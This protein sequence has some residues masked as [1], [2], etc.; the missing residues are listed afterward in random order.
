MEELSR[1]KIDT[2]LDNLIANQRAVD[3]Q[4]L[5]MQLARQKWPDII[6]SELSHDGGEDGFTIL[7][8]SQSD[9]GI[10]VACSLTATKAKILLD[11]RRIKERKIQVDLLVF[12]TPRILRRLT[13]EPWQKEVNEDFHHDLQVISREDIAEM[14]LQPHNAWMC[15]RYLKLQISEQDGIDALKNRAKD[16]TKRIL[17]GWKRE[18]GFDIARS[19]GLDIQLS[20]PERG[21]KRKIIR[22]ED[23]SSLLK[24]C[25]QIHLRGVPGAGKS[26]TLIQLAES[27]LCEKGD[28]LP[29][30]ISLPEWSSHGEDLISFIAGSPAI[31]SQRLSKMDLARLAD[32]SH[33]IFLMNGWN[34]VPEN[35]ISDM[36]LRLGKMLRE[37]PACSF[38]ISTRERSIA[39]PR[40]PGSLLAELQPLSRPQRR[41]FVSLNCRDYE[42]NLINRLEQDPI[43]DEVSKTP[44]FLKAMIKSWIREKTL[45]NSRYRLLEAL[46]RDAEESPEHRTAINSGITSLYH[47]SFL[48]HIAAAM[49]RTGGAVLNLDD[50]RVAVTKCGT[51]LMNAQK[52]SILPDSLKVI[53][54]LTEH[55]LLKR[56]SSEPVTIQFVHQEFQDWFAAEYLF[57]Q[58][59]ALH[60][61]DESEAVR[62]LQFQCI[63]WPAWESSILLYA[64]RLKHLFE[65]DRSSAIATELASKLVGSSIL[66]DLVFA[67]S[68]LNLLQGVCNQATHQAF[69]GRVSQL[70]KKTQDDTDKEYVLAAIF[71]SCS[72]EFKDILWPLIEDPNDQVRLGTYRILEPFPTTCLGGG[73]IDR[74]RWWDEDRRRELIHEVCSRGGVMAVEIAS[75]FAETDP[76]IS[77]RAAAINALVWGGAPTAAIRLLD[78]IGDEVFDTENGAHLP[79]LLPSDLIRP[80]LQR[81]KA[82]YYKIINR[83]F[84]TSVIEFLIEIDDPEGLEFLSNWIEQEGLKKIPDLFLEK[85]TKVYPEWIATKVGQ[86]IL[87]GNEI[88][89]YQART[90]KDLPTAFKDQIGDMVLDENMPMDLI[91]KR[92]YIFGKFLT[93]RVVRELLSRF[94][95]CQIQIVKSKAGDHDRVKVNY[96][97]DLGL[98]I[99]ELNRVII[100]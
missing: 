41:K 63:N 56:T 25:H 26:H 33:L 66:I 36:E 42:N 11:C 60:E 22:L 24:D 67:G 79:A 28:L 100:F 44:L 34:E 19:I 48:C 43:L 16:A 97:R 32:S 27:F 51:E 14:L 92:I 62:Y 85:A 64:D 76:S 75:R 39:P 83:K 17:E 3:F 12:Y 45:P 86:S 31:M 82:A 80:R 18:F 70:W 5:A 10:S 98:I 90:L 91:R 38:V 23:L 99:R 49:C 68:L 6:A 55:H 94:V 59:I 73:W 87:N 58:H 69:N 9:K 81:L 21:N 52:I 74:V 46:I 71:A 30:L 65:N 78:N 77:V 15:R 2:A 20:L 37:I 84:R 95:D 57:D 53:D 1:A 7:P 54:L 93:K 47:R 96:A 35:Q 40:L 29:L 61:K 72:A 50:V 8:L 13:W 88:N 89:Q 4:R